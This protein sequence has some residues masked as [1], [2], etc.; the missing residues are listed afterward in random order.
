MEAPSEPRRCVQ[1]LELPSYLEQTRRGGGALRELSAR[2][3]WCSR[4]SGLGQAFESARGTHH[5]AVGRSPSTCTAGVHQRDRSVGLRQVDVDSHP[6]RARR[7]RRAARCGSTASEVAGPAPTAAWC[8]RATRCFRGCSVS[9]NVMFGLRM[10]GCPA[11]KA[12]RQAARVARRGRA[13]AVCRPL[14]GA[15]LGRHEAARGDRARAGQRAAHPADGRAVRRARRADALR[16]AGA[17]ARAS[18]TASTSPS[19]SSPTTWT[20]PSTCPIASWCSRRIPGASPRSSTCRCRARATAA[21]SCRARSWR[22]RSGSSA[23]PRQLDD[24]D[25]EQPRR[26]HREAKH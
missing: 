6:G 15:A 7:S 10:R 22:P 19:C 5:R 21:S 13:D 20:K 12:E 25:R 18:G 3:R 9:D 2:G 14:S 11:R 1:T 24:E 16:H 26:S 17:P 4:S 8:S 23:D